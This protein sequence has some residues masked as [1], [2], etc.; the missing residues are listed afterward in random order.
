MYIR[1]I[2]ELCIMSP[3]FS[4]LDKTDVAQGVPFSITSRNRGLVSVYARH[5]NC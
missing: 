2:K 1:T 5:A 4:F 3:S